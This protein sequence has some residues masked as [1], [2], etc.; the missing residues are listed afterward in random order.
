MW[1]GRLKGLR[2]HLHPRAHFFHAPDH[3]LITGLDRSHYHLHLA[4][5]GTEF[6]G[7]R[8]HHVVRS[9]QYHQVVTLQFHGCRLRDNQR[10]F[11]FLDRGR[12][13][14]EEARPQDVFV[15]RKQ[16]RYLDGPGGNVHLPVYKVETAFFRINRAVGKGQF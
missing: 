9:E 12:Y 5:G 4:L 8:L 7:R 6:D 11:Q 10:P 1:R 15:V 13:A 16:S 14:R 3:N 2:V